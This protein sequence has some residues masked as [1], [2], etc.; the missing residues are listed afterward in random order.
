V[1]ALL[2]DDKASSASSSAMG[3]LL[4]SKWA[5]ENSPEVVAALRE[6]AE[7]FRLG[8]RERL[9]RECSDQMFINR[10]PACSRVLRTPRARQCLWCSHSWHVSDDE[11]NSN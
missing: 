10:C 3:N 1:K 8:V 9:V 6:G 7:A 5:S 11:L 2:V 4:R